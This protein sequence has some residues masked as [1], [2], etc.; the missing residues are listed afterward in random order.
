MSSLVGNSLSI[1]KV[2]MPARNRRLF[3]SDDYS[4]RARIQFIG[5]FQTN[6]LMQMRHFSR[7]QSVLT[8]LRQTRLRHDLLPLFKLD[9][10]FIC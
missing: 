10:V 4:E 3:Q 6:L 5:Y 9:R 8:R 2:M 1:W 7:V